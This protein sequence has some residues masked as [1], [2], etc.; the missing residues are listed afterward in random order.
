MIVVVI[1]W[2]RDTKVSTTHPPTQASV[3]G[4]VHCHYGAVGPVLLQEGEMMAEHMTFDDPRALAGE[5][6][7]K[8]LFAIVSSH[9]F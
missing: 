1:G 6:A 8:L 5:W 2:I 3:I 9:V 4:P 7:V